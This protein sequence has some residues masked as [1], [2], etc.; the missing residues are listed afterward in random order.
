MMQSEWTITGEEGKALDA[1]RRSVH[2]VGLASSVL[3]LHS[4]DVDAISWTVQDGIVPDKL[5]EIALW[6]DG[7]RVF[8]GKITTR[9]FVYDSRSG[10]QYSLVASGALYEMSK[11]QIVSDV[12]DD[13]GSTT[14]RPTIQFSPGN[15]RDMVSRLIGLAPGVDA[16]EIAEM[17]SVGRKS[18]TSGTWLAVLLELLKPVADVAGWVDYSFDPPRLNIERRPFMETIRCQI[19]VDAVARVELN[20]KTELRVTGISLASASRDASGKV[21]FSAQT[22]GDGSQIVSVSGPE[23]GAFVPP[24]NLPSVTIKTAALDST[25]VRTLDSGLSAIYNKFGGIYGA[26]GDQ[27]V[28]YTGTSS[29]K[30]YDPIYFPSVW[31]RDEAGNTVDPTGKFLVVSG[32]LPDWAVTKYGAIRVLISGTWLDSSTSG[33]SNAIWEAIKSGGAGGY[34]GWAYD[35]PGDSTGV[36]YASRQWSIDATL[37]NQAFAVDT[38]V[39][40][41]A[42]YEYLQP[43]AGMAEGMFAA[44]DFLPYEGQVKLH[45]GFPWQRFLGRR[46]NVLGADPDLETAGALVQAVSIDIATGTVDLRCGAPGRVSLASVISR[47]S[48]TTKDNIVN[49]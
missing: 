43:P 25:I 38:M 14:A 34:A 42:A 20:P 7:V 24:D 28:R 47:Y 26:I 37:I 33:T 39:Y 3:E 6:R 30:V 1:T 17:F 48:P 35:T 23:V 8:K 29:A 46:I 13:L 10:Q 15:L 31:Y 40:E 32:N 21:V 12:A 44:A 4:L 22:A 19:G 49:I 5:Q 11:A 9:K 27:L 45:P 18:F 16:G 2:E 36:Y 41:D